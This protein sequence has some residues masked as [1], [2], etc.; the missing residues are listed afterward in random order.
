MVCI[1]YIYFHHSLCSP[2]RA[3]QRWHCI[4]W[5]MT[6]P[7]VNDEAFV[8]MPLPLFFAFDRHATHLTKC[9]WPSLK[10][11]QDSRPDNTQIRIESLHFTHI[12][13]WSF[14]LSAVVL[15][16]EDLFCKPS[17]GFIF[18][19]KWWTARVS[20]CP[21]M[22]SCLPVSAERELLC[23]CFS[24]VLLDWDLRKGLTGV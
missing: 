8:I 11:P 22:E 3:T 5:C 20:S 15:F 24:S 23:F 12:V 9:K 6:A 4:I 16:L 13:I 10:I 2:Q 19:M 7:H 1:S 17:Q 21:K 14:C 18:T